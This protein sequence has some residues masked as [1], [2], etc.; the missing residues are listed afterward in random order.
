MLLPFNV[1]ESDLVVEYDLQRLR[2][3][4]KRPAAASN[5]ATSHSDHSQPSRVQSPATAPNVLAGVRLMDIVYGEDEVDRG[6]GPLRPFDE[7]AL[8]P[9]ASL[10][11]GKLPGTTYNPLPLRELFATGSASATATTATATATTT[12]AASLPGKQ[13]A[14]TA[15][16]QTPDSPSKRRRT[17]ASAADHNVTI[18]HF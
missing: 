8:R 11:P 13:T 5:P 16:L 15:Q 12:A 6:S 3:Q 9:L 1:F 14:S 7:E 2:E 17:G 10:M 4:L 18:Q